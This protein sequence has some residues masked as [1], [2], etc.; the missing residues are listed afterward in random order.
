MAAAD[1]DAYFG[2]RSEHMRYLTGFVLDDGEDE[3]GQVAHV[4]GSNAEVR[5]HVCRGHAITKPAQ[6]DR[7]G[8]RVGLRPAGSVGIARGRL[9][10]GGMRQAADQLVMAP[11]Y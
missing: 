2:I 9:E 4:L 8:G 1:V 10:V 7:P 11:W 5:V 6:A 3:A